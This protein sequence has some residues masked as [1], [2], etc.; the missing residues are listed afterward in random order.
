MA[1]GSFFKSKDAKTDPT[2]IFNVRL[3]FLLCAIS[4]AGMF[5][6]F[7]QGNIGGIMELPS[8]ERS[9]GLEHDT[10]K[11]SDDKKGSI[12]AMLAAGGGNI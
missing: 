3:L 8:F 6:G 2:E 11:Q 4:W 7:D 12:A 10:Q 1:G 9:L 5:Y